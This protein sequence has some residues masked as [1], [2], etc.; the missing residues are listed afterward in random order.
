MRW[1]GFVFLL[2]ACLLSA[3]TS[4]PQPK[5]YQFINGQW[6]D[7]RG[8]RDQTFYS[9]NGFLTRKKPARVDEVVDLKNGYVV[10]P[11]AD[12]HCHH[13]Q[14]RSAAQQ[15]EMYLTDGVFYAKVQANVRSDTLQVRNKV[16]RPMS[17]DVSYA[18]GALTSSY[19]HGIEV[20]EG[21]ALYSRTW[22]FNAEEIKIIRESR[23]RENDAYYII[24]T[25]EDLER[26]WS[27]ILEG[28][29]DF[30][31]IYLLTSEEFEERK[32]RTDTVGDRGLDPLLVPLIVARAHAAR[33]R[34]SAHVDTVTDYRI[35]L[36]AGV[37]E[38][39]HLPGYYIGPKDDT[40]K[41]EL[42]AEDV[43]ETARHGVWV[44]IAPVVIENYDL[45][46]SL[47]KV[48]AK[49]RIDA[50]RVHNLRLLKKFKVKIAFGSDWY[51]RTPVI[52]VLYLQ[53]LSVFSNLEMLKIWCEETP[54]S[55]FPNRKIGLLKAGYEANFIVLDGNPLLDFEQIK[56]IRLRFKQ[57]Y[58]LDALE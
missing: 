8:F 47:M 36:K 28:K 58:F 13:F 38:M 57:G 54:R 40:R 3:Q 5:S 46:D 39:A 56:K 26:K 17:V 49:E 48:Q 43:K 19:G 42:T 44:D 22:G 51:G 11:F 2:A 27:R 20:Y 32:K 50:V 52:D 23:L 1:L 55:I 35:A 6:F 53:K 9:V 24:D 41:Y 16:N 33:L 31:K 7:G 18:H 45:Q 34:V 4:L 15:V 21:L 29:P 37:D 14:N 12:A 10:P 30:I 25:A